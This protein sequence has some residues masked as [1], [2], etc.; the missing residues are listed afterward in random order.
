[1]GWNYLRSGGI[2]IL[3]AGKSIDKIFDVNSVNS[4]LMMI[5]LLIGKHVVAIVSVYASQQGLTEDVM[6]LPC[7]KSWRKSAGHT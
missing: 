6:D 1:M 5:K 4:K 2:G 7:L 3:V